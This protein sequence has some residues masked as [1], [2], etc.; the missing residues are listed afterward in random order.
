[1]F[2]YADSASKCNA[3]SY[4]YRYAYDYDYSHRYANSD[5]Y[6]YRHTECYGSSHDY[7]Y[8]YPLSDSYGYGQ[9][10]T[11]RKAQRNAKATSYSATPP[12]RDVAWRFW[13]AH[14]SRVLVSASTPK[15]TFRMRHN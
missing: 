13:G 5:R 14:A 6:G 4:R 7:T 8:C 1:M 12:L 3:N 2:T 15:R 9:T 11:Y 10:N